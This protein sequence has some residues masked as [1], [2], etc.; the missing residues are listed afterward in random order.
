MV[1]TD[2]RDYSFVHSA[3]A[4]YRLENHTLLHLLFCRLNKW[5]WFT[6]PSRDASYT[7][8]HPWCL[9]SASKGSKAS[10]KCKSPS[11]I[12]CSSTDSDNAELRTKLT[13][14]ILPVTVLS[15]HASARVTFWYSIVL[16]NKN[17]INPFLKDCYHLL[18]NKCHSFS[19]PL[20][21][22]YW[23]AD[24]FSSF[25]RSFWNVILFSSTVFSQF[26]VN[27]RMT[28]VTLCFI[29]QFTR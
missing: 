28:P 11:W 8:E 20:T 22:T 6:L 5:K 3:T 1:T 16:S 17:N 4:F 13:L 10:L 2:T 9:C 14:L 21:I 7:S 26:C 27:C 15:V 29:I 12:Q 25:A 24:Y 19:S 23:F 18:T